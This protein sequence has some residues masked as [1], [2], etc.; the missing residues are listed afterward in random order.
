MN[1]HMTTHLNCWEGSTTA[2]GEVTTPAEE[3]S[4]GSGSSTV[5][6]P[7]TDLVDASTSQGL[8]FDEDRTMN[9]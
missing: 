5:T 6:E 3:L 2:T 7:G 9:T 8:A 4:R 1:T